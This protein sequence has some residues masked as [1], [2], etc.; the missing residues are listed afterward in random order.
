MADR[1]HYRRIYGCLRRAVYFYHTFLQLD[2]FRVR[3]RVRECVGSCEV[4]LL[5]MNSLSVTG[6]RI[7][8]HGMSALV[9]VLPRL[10]VKLLLDEISRF[11][12]NV[13][14]YVDTNRMFAILDLLLS[15]N[16][17][18]ETLLSPPLFQDEIP[19]VLLVT[20]SFFL[21][22]C[23]SRRRFESPA[24]NASVGRTSPS[25]VRRV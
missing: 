7:F 15:V 18:W 1:R 25:P 17:R 21:L 4:G 6:G 16:V 23:Y 9:T 24:L 14:G 22:S 13:V 11:E 12:C 8:S 10:T 5:K 20:I 19:S 3:V 2:G